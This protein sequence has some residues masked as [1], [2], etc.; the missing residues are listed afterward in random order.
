MKPFD[1]STDRFFNFTALENA[2]YRA[3]QIQ[4]CNF[5]CGKGEGENFI[6]FHI[7]SYTEKKNAEE[8]I[9]DKKSLLSRRVL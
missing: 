7:K 1:M 8:S 6:A 9:F 4:K 3:S 5:I 2:F